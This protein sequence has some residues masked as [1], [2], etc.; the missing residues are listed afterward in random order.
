MKTKEEIFTGTKLSGILMLI[1][2]FLLFLGTV[3]LF[4]WNVSS[5]ELNIVIKITLFVITAIM[6][7]LNCLFWGGFMQIE[8][9]E[10][11]VMI[12]P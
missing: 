12:L 1:L 11:M 5:I 2:N 9:N 4:A 6:F 8:P 3:S 10:A 7:I